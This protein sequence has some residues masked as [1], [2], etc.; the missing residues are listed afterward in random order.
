[1]TVPAGGVEDGNGVA[2]RAV[3]RR[4]G[5]CLFCPEPAPDVLLDVEDAAS[6]PGFP[7]TAHRAC[8]ARH[9]EPVIGGYD[10]ER[11]GRAW[12]VRR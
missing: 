11:W 7:V 3:T 12:G 2:A 10:P 8:A 6:G 5:V 9:H 4:F 1:M